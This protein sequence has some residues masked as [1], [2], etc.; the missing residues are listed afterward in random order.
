MT[1]YKDAG[2]R[3]NHVVHILSAIMPR[4]SPSPPEVRYNVYKVRFSLAMSDPDTFGIRYHTV[5]Y[6]ELDPGTR[7]GELH[8]VVGDLVTG[9]KYDKRPGAQP[10]AS[11]SFYNK[12]LLGTVKA[13]SLL[14]IESICSELPPPP[15]QKSFNGITRRTEP[16][17]PDG[18]FYKPGE[19]RAP[20]VKCTEWTEQ[21]AIPAL[22]QSG[23]LE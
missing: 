19:P 5:I 15:K 10:E 13:S 23:V 12:E 6:V 18:S 16:I 7:T 14:A 3:H 21:Q 4:R 1:R 20:L 2:I 22:Y 17:K 8:H 9:M 11:R